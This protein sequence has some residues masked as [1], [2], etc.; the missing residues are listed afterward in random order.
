MDNVFNKLIK[1]KKD[2]FNP[3]IFYY[4]KLYEL[5]N[6]IQMLTGHKVHIKEHGINY[7][8]H[9]AV[10]KKE[11]DNMYEDYLKDIDKWENI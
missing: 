11:I 3:K 9:L 1:F 10:N 4:D 2:K 6:F 8:K 5:A 7:K